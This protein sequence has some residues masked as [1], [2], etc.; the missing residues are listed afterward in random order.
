MFLICGATSLA[1]TVAHAQKSKAP[2][3]G[4]LWHAADAEAQ[5]ACFTALVQGFRD[6]GYADGQDILLEHRFAGEM[7][8]KFRD[9]AAELVALDIDVLVT[10]GPQTA[11]YAKIATT[12][13]PTVFMGVPDPVGSKFV[14]SL[15]RPRRNMTGLSNFGAD[16]LAKRLEF[17]K[18]MVPGLS[19][20]ALLVNPKNP[21]TPLY[22]RVTETAAEL[23]LENHT[24]EATS[25]EEL[26]RAFDAMVGAGM[27]AVT[28][29]AD[30]LAFQHRTLI[31]RMTLARHLPLGVWSRESFDGGALISYG[32]DQVAMCRHAPVF[33]DKILKGA[34]PGDL[35]VEQP[36]KLDLLINLKVARDLGLSVP[37]M[38]L[39]LAD[40][41]VE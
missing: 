18:D 20:V 36:T 9:L 1:S 26:G 4:I 33:V 23:G 32:P 41:V 10:V 30:G 37:P 21:V 25:L 7:P 27:Q 5:G 19:G 3:V 39:A 6:L 11:P 12:T 29:N 17:L 2:R 40:E 14:E 22:R 35:P 8:E 24:F 16:I 34:K 15:A 13:I 38:L 31:G 28:I